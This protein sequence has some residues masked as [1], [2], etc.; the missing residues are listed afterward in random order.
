MDRERRP[1]TRAGPDVANVKICASA[2]AR[3]DTDGRNRKGA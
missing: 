3:N 2:G 1:E